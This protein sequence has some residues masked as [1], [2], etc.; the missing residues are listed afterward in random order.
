MSFKRARKYL[1]LF[2]VG[3][4]GYAA[5]EIIW[6]GHTHWSMAI[7]GGIC[8]ILFSHVARIFRH[9]GIIIKAAICALAVTLV[10]LLFGIIFN[11]ILKMN[12]WDYSDRPLNLLGQVCP[13]F[14]L[15]WGGL[16][17]IFLPLADLIARGRRAPYR[18]Y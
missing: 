1:I 9:K 11:I 12:V 4:A 18:R 5:I 3:A 8:F 7:A 17:I 6:R 2:F 16:S 15:M 13:L 14:T 10:E